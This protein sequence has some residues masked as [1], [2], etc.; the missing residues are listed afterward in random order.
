[1]RNAVD[2]ESLGP[3][4]LQRKIAEDDSASERLLAYLDARDIQHSGEISGAT[5]A[6]V[7]GVDGRTWRKWVTAERM[8]VAATRVLI[9]AAYCRGSK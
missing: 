7:C 8:P 4:E 2:L 5:L 6:A 1:M 9:C 3:R